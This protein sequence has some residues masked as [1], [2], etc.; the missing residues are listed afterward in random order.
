MAASANS[1]VADEVPSG[2]QS[3]Q[4]SLKAALF[5]RGHV[6]EAVGYENTVGVIAHH[7]LIESRINEGNAPLQKQDCMSRR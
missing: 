2:K 5:K 6:A 1:F 7:R 3:P 4:P